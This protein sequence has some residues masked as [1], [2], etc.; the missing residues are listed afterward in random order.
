MGAGT[1]MWVNAGGEIGAKFAAVMD[2]KSHTNFISAMLKPPASE[3]AEKYVLDFTNCTISEG[4]TFESVMAGLSA[5]AAH[6]TD[7]GFQN[8]TYMMF[9]VF[10][11]SNNDYAFKLVE[12]HDNH[13]ALGADYELMG[14]AGHWMKQRELL[15]GLIDCDIPRVYDARTI[16]QWADDDAAE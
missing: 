10:G 5:W 3:D 13:T 6:Q 2:C 12:G 1:D 11:E 4:Q 7:S 14:N 16:R 8:S 9:P 15:S